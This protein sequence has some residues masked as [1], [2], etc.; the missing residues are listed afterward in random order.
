MHTEIINLDS[1]KV[2]S[3]LLGI[4]S[5]LILV[6]LVSFV[7]KY[8]FGHSDL[9]GLIP[10]FSL[11]VSAPNIPTLFSTLLLLICSLLLSVISIVRGRK[12]QGAEI[13]VL[14]LMFSFFTINE[15]CRLYRWISPQIR[16]SIRN[17]DL[18]T[19]GLMVL[20]GVFLVIFTVNFSRFVFRAPKRS[21]RLFSISAALFVFGAFFLDAVGKILGDGQGFYD[22]F[23]TVFEESLEMIGLVV[24]A[25]G[26]MVYLEDLW[27]G[28]I[29]QV[30]LGKPESTLS[31]QSSGSR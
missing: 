6:Q 17:S 27:D 14:A 21:R 4:S 2:L 13:S 24:F 11:A 30:G 1:K 12:Q 23:I 7:S 8:I 18:F 3:L 29:M 10:L 16:L 19:A 22:E 20:F 26:L 25:H 28:L 5:F 9:F 15:F 31:K